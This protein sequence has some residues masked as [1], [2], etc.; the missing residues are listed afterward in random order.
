M[1]SPLA[2]GKQA[3]LP[4][5]REAVQD[6]VDL[7]PEVGERLDDLPASSWS[8]LGERYVEGEV[9]VQAYFHALRPGG[10]VWPTRY[11]CAVFERAVEEF[12]RLDWDYAAFHLRDAGSALSG[13]ATNDVERFVLVSVGE[14]TQ[15]PKRMPLIRI[16]SV[17]RLYVFDDGLGVQGHAP[18]LEVAAGARPLLPVRVDR[19]ED[20]KA[21][22]SGG[23]PECLAATIHA[24]WSR[25]VCRWW[26]ASLMR[27]A[28]RGSGARRTSTRQTFSP[29]SG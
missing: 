3:R 24:M 2:H 9:D 6:R 17:V 8:R 20:R 16:P 29:V 21:G 23:C 1:Y 4:E 13:R 28:Q 19:A 22:P 10:R 26:T 12:D 15:D 5:G 27:I 11:Y 7:V 25:T 18:G 14:S